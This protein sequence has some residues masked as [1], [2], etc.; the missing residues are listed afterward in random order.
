MD[1]ATAI[2]AVVV[3][4]AMHNGMQD[5][6][7]HET[8]CDYVEPTIRDQKWVQPRRLIEMRRSQISHIEQV[9]NN[10]LIGAPRFH[11]HYVDGSIAQVYGPV[12]RDFCEPV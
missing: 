1:A 10:S 9:P 3:L 4:S 8:T 5:R 7:R 2:G 6:P 11:V 12:A